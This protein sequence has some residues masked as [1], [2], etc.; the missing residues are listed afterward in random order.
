MTDTG[1]RGSKLGTEGSALYVTLCQDTSSQENTEEN[2][3]S[4]EEDHLGGNFPYHPSPADI[5]QAFR[6]AVCSGPFLASKKETV[7]L[8]D[9]IHPVVVHNYNLSAL[10][11]IHGKFMF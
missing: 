10:D 2:V 6:R 9:C 8:V 4:L 7:R 11:T 1:D 5:F 3:E